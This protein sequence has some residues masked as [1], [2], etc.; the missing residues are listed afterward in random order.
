MLLH[1][2]FTVIGARAE[3]SLTTAVYERSFAQGRDF[4]WLHFLKVR[5]TDEVDL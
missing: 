2:H 1:G 4:T 3:L 5:L